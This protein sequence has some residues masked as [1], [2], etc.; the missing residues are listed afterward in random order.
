[1]GKFERL[2]DSE[3]HRKI[4]SFCKGA[5]EEGRE[6]KFA[7]GGQ[8]LAEGGPAMLNRTVKNNTIC[9]SEGG[10][11]L[12]AIKTNS[13]MGAV[14]GKKMKMGGMSEFEHSTSPS[15]EPHQRQ[16]E[17]KEAIP[18]KFKDGGMNESEEDLKKMRMRKGGDC[19]AAGGV[20]KIRHD[21]M[22]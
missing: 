18:K 10:D 20:G 3:F 22:D 5:H 4:R 14:S 6:Q 16:F 7:D 1:M 9:K 17:K 15:K 13:A 19:R 11:M 8:V 2:Q 12:K 21:Q